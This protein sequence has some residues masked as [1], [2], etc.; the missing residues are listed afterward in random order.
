MFNTVDEKLQLLALSNEEFAE[1]LANLTKFYLGNKKN[2]VEVS[3]EKS[4]SD[5]IGNYLAL[6][7]NTPVL[8]G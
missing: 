5:I 3:V 4:S 7:D 8:G 6:E 2:S 1:G